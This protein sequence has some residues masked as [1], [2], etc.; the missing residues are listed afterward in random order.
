MKTGPTAG[1]AGQNQNPVPPEDAREPV[2]LDS[3]PMA[4]YSFTV[5][6]YL[7]SGAKITIRG[8]VYAR[9]GLYYQARARVLDSVLKEIPTL[10]LDENPIGLRMGRCIPTEDF[11]FLGRSRARRPAPV[12]ATAQAGNSNFHGPAGQG[13]QG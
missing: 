9:K 6:G 11:G 12:S 2:L 4:R 5:R 8:A 3:L 13:V 10:E 7:A 1:G